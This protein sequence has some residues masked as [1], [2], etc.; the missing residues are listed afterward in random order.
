MGW[1]TF[2]SVDESYFR[3]L[4]N[5]AEKWGDLLPYKVTVSGEEHYGAGITGSEPTSY[6]LSPKIQHPTGAK[7]RIKIKYYVWIG[8]NATG[9]V[10]LGIVFYDNGNT[11]K[12]VEGYDL[13][14]V[15]HTASTPPSESIAEP[16]EFVLEQE[17]NRIVYSVDGDKVGEAQLQGT[18]AGF[19]IATKI[20]EASN[21]E[22]GIIITSVTAEY[23]DV[24]EDWVN[25]MMSIM[26]IMMYV[27]IGVAVVALLIRA[28][29]REKEGGG[30]S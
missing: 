10:E 9:K 20:D 27:M 6:L 25:Q 18:L 29:K 19:K 26:N 11:V 5:R 2:Y 28:F 1:K 14:G 8:A 7:T 16:H 15:A 13:H 30:G 23:Y 17:M 22:V 12:D 21:G 3:D 4:Y 24:I